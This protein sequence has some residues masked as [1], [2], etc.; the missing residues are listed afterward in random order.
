MDEHIVYVEQ[1]K[2]VVCRTCK[3]CIRPGGSYQHFRR[4]HKDLG[5][6]V[7]KELQ[8]YCD[9]LDLANPKDVPVHTDGA[10]IDG[11]T[12]YTGR[13]CT[14]PTCSTLTPIPIENP[15]D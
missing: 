2:V 8:S 9:A 3:Y 7:R 11:L 13:R 1:Y 5:L 15:S 4:W 12:L 6:L 10:T 14:I